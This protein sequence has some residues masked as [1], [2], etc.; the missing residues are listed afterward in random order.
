M[1]H[2]SGWHW[3][4]SGCTVSALP[5]TIRVCTLP[6]TDWCT[7]W[8]SSGRGSSVT[9]CTLTMLSWSADRDRSRSIFPWCM[10]P[11]WS[12]MSSSSRRLWEETRTVV[13]CSATSSKIMRM[14]C[15][16]ITG[17]RPSTGSSRMSTSGRQEMASQK[18][19]CFC[20]PLEKRRMGWRWLRAKTS[21][22]R[23]NRPSSKLG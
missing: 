12:Q 7:T 11:T 2:S 10:M 4:S 9:S 5:R 14:I 8:S 3:A 21:P 6:T 18:A 23:S 1:S 16:R 17:S 20:M 15:R 13:P 19:A 22:S